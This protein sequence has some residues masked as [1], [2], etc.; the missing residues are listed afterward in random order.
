M[1]RI[2]LPFS[3]AA[4]A[5][6]LHACAAGQQATGAGGAA[7]SSSSTGSAG[8]GGSMKPPEDDGGLVISDAATE[9]PPLSPDAACATAVEEAQSTPLPV[10]IIWAVDN[11]ASMQ[12]AIAQIKLG[13]NA[14]AAL[15]G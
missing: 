9:E 14:F 8:V 11:S 10:D 13:L 3:V 2:L 15:V 12:P 6:S 5:L 1:R 7:A 4:L